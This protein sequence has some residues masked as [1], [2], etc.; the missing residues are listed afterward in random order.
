MSGQHAS[1]AERGDLVRELRAE[2]EIARSALAREIAKNAE[3]VRA[4]QQANDAMAVEAANLRE[5][6]V[7]LKQDAAAAVSAMAARAVEIDVRAHLLEREHGELVAA[8]REALHALDAGEPRRV[9]EILERVT[10]F[11]A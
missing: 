5:G 6:L 8:A 2:L 7:R 1:I 9:R 4:V 11:D 3:F 10:G